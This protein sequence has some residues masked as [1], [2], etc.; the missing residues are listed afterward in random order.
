MKLKIERSFLKANEEILR[1]ILDTYKMR[2]E[3]SMA[4]KRKM[5][6]YSH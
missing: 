4:I 3:L 2:N 1:D 5:L 6:A